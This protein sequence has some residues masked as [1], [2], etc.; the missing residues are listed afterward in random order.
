MASLLLWYDWTA[1]EPPTAI[2]VRMRERARQ[3]GAVDETERTGAGWRAWAARTHPAE[4]NPLWGLGTETRKLLLVDRAPASLPADAAGLDARGWLDVLEDGSPTAAVLL[5]PARG[6]ITALRDR[7]GQRALCWARVPGGIVLASGEHVLRAHPAV[8]DALDEL[9]LACFLSL[10][11]GPA[12]STVWK[13]VRALACGQRLCW[14]RRGQRSDTRRLRP[15]PGLATLEDAE[16]GEAFVERLQGATARAAR[17]YG[18]PGLSLSGGMDSSAVAVALRAVLGCHTP[19]DALTFGFDAWPQTDERA[20]AKLTA[21][22]LGLRQHCLRADDLDPLHPELA[23][24]VCP[25]TPFQTPYR[26]LKEASYR[27]LRA[28][29][30]DC[31]FSGNFGDHLWA[32]PRHWLTEALAHGDWSSVVAGLGEIWR[33]RGARGLLADWGLRALLRPGRLAA[34]PAPARLAWLTPRWRAEVEAHWRAELDALRDWPRPAQALATLGAAAAFDAHGETWYAQR[35]GLA[36]LQ[37]FRDEALTRWM[38][39]LPAQFSFRGGRWKHLMRLALR[40]RLPREISSRPKASDLSHWTEAARQR[41][42]A[43]W[44]QHA[45]LARAQLPMLAP[46]PEHSQDL[47]L[48]WQL[49]AFGLWWQRQ[50]APC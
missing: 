50:S 33:S 14:T 7:M 43:I 24:P 19:I 22:R 11:P 47:A 45:D 16:L 46:S 38:L 34:E 29:G 21:E 37:P 40:E 36:V 26:E 17:G 2:W 6:E 44:A 30:A 8:S 5:D 48:A 31:V 41:R 3:R 39:S 15:E 18:R 27:L 35:H 13:D 32:H 42:R 4:P 10:M 25:D 49:A 12:E 23:R 28:A 9:W 20:L 1:A